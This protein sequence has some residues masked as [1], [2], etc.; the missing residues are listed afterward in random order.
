MSGRTRKNKIVGQFA[1]R[2]IEMIESPA[3]RVLS[4][5]GRRVQDRLE[6]EHASHG[7][8]KNGKLPVTYGDFVDFGMDRQAIAP[9]I[10][11]LVALGFLEITERGRPSESDFGRH[12]NLFRIT[13][14][15]GNLK[16]THEWRRHVSIA[17]ADKVAKA[18]RACKDPR[19]VEKARSRARFKARTGGGETSVLDGKTHPVVAILPGGK[20]PPTTLGLDSHPTLYI[21]GPQ[22]AVSD[23][24][25]STHNK[26]HTSSG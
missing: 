19:A 1:A 5:S 23:K 15:M 25:Q 11:E 18:A 2:L 16:P 4:L 12:P 3:M 9:A 22:V 13:Y 6:I 14:L 20:F 26:V 8:T 24:G 21:S 10:R 7:G 17:E